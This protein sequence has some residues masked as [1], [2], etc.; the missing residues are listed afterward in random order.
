MR[1]LKIKFLIFVFLFIQCTNRQL[2][3][4]DIIVL[5][6][7]FSVSFKT[8]VL[9]KNELSLV[10][11]RY[12]NHLEYYS[13][14]ESIRLRITIMIYDDRIPNEDFYLNE[15]YL[16]DE[17]LL[18]K[19]FERSLSKKLLICNQTIDRNMQF[20]SVGYLID[21]QLFHLDSQIKTTK[22]RIR[23]LITMNKKNNDFHKILRINN[24]ILQ[25]IKI[26]PLDLLRS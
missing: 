22:L 8:G 7:N 18:F 15:L 26:K 17:K 10:E 25:T 12:I 9:F 11:N 6:N 4:T 2:Y 1:D 5:D 21:N 20:S 13:E 3:L 23:T 19:Y 16:A 14:D 24:E